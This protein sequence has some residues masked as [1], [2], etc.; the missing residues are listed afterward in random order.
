MLVSTEEERSGGS[1]RS[2]RNALMVL[3]P[4]LALLAG[5]YLVAG[6]VFAG[7]VSTGAGVPA[8]KVAGDAGQQGKSKYDSPLVCPPNYEI[9]QTENAT[10]VPGTDLVPGSQCDDCSFSISLPFAYTL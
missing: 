4:L 2:L 8:N 10:P 7:E 9:V 1:P 6:R 3:L 5:S